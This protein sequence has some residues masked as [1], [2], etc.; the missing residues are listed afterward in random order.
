MPR[1]STRTARYFLLFLALG[2][3]IVG[4]A[5]H[6][7]EKPL[8]YSVLGYVEEIQDGGAKLLIDHEEIPGYMPP[9]IM[10]FQVH[11]AAL[12]PSLAP[13]DQIRFRYVVEPGRSWISA[14]EATGQSRPVTELAPDLKP[15]LQIGDLLPDCGF[16]NE[17]GQAVR[18]SDY[19]GQP[20]A[21][22]FIFTRCPTPEYCPAM[23]RHF[24][25]AHQLLQSHP[26]AP[27]AW[28]LLTLS[29]DPEHDTP[30][31]M[32]R[33]G[34][35]Y[36]YASQDWSL[37]TQGDPQDFQALSQGI[38]LKFGARNGSIL[39]NLRTVVLDREGRIAQC[40]TDEDWTPEQLV[41]AL[42]QADQPAG[43]LP[44]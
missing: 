40:F 41:E 28:K 19:R 16:V 15:L 43:E 9:M 27:K 10:S 33:F 1:P 24:G 11:D 18:L 31:V 5:P 7:S 3:F 32:Q 23:M 6:E 39:H 17:Y 34:Q 26:Q 4:C 13:G 22:T 12:P 44:H 8:E 25:A 14:I 21:L 37:L 35:A 2:A 38:G 20:I 42:I 30:E 36:G 29:F